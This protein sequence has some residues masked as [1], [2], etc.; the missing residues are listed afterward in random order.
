MKALKNFKNKKILITGHTGFKGSW[1]TLWLWK[2]GAKLMCVSN[3]VLTYPNHY[4][5]LNFLNLITEKKFDI[6]ELKKIKKLIF[7]FK[8]DYIFHLAAQALVKESYVDPIKTWKSN[9]FGTLNILHSLK[10]YKKNCSVV[11]I[12]S[13]KSYKNLEIK[14][15]YKENDI[16]GGY[17]PYSASKAA[18]ELAIQSYYKSF[19]QHRK[20]IKLAVARAGNVI[21]GGD[22]SN[23]RIFPDAMK[24]LKNNKKLLLR[25]PNSTRPWQ[26]V[27]EAI[28]GYLLLAIS[29]KKKNKNNEAFNFGP[30]LSNNHNVLKLVKEIKKNFP[31]FKWKVFK[32]Q[33]KK[34]YESSLLKLNSNKA[35]KIL[36]WQN[37]LSF[38]ETVKL[39]SDWYLGFFNKKNIFNLSINQIKKYEKILLK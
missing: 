6:Y 1:L 9:T 29:L 15:G 14:R 13:D 12:T 17:D 21:G 25:N 10:D 27:L 28:Y 32:N 19:L 38:F 16:L 26:H 20:N 22:W 37:K 11:I 34:K 7:D 5:S 35:K 23:D 3:G 18:A 2:L 39:T 33:N 8:P 4:Q 31:R 36:G 30:R 24:S